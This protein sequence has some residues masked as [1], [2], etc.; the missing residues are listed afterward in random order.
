[1]PVGTVIIWPSAIN[2]SDGNVW[3]ECN[4]QS[5]SSYPL[6]AAIVGSNVPNYRGYFLRGYG[7]NSAAIN[8]EQGDAIRNIKDTLSAFGVG[9][10]SS[11]SGLFTGSGTPIHFGCTWFYNVG[12]GSVTFD[13]SK[14][15]PTA[16]ENRPLNKAV[17]YLIRAQ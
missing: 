12:N 9:F 16:S 17:R 2:P 7:G 10:Y 15:V 5:T 6:L 4:G 13:A 3:L 14:V 8:I 1:M 11:S